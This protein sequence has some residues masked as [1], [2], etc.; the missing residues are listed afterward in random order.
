[1]LHSP[2]GHSRS[3]RINRAVSPL[4]S[5]QTSSRFV[6]RLSL[7]TFL[8]V[9]LGQFTFGTSRHDGTNES[10]SLIQLPF[11]GAILSSRTGESERNRGPQ[12]IWQ[13]AMRTSGQVRDGMGQSL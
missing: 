9:S 5:G 1:M 12:V 6:L 4:Q 11:Y 8:A 3:S 2:N 13:Q 10:G 7:H